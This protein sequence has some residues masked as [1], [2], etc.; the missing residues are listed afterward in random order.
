MRLVNS[1]GQLFDAHLTLQGSFRYS[2]TLDEDEN[3]NFNDR[4]SKK[5]LTLV[6]FILNFI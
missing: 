5:R 1:A 2:F 6:N 3:G 4:S